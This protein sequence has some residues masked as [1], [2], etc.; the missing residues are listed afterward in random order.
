MS[1][2]KVSVTWKRN[3]P[4]FSYETYDRTHDWRFEGGTAVTATAAPEFKGNPDLVDPESAFVASLSSCHLLSFLAIAARKRFTVDSYADH[5]VGTLE[6]NAEGKL[7]MTRVVLRP[8]VT[9]GGE[10]APEQAEIRQLHE[11]AHAICFIAN[12]VRTEVVV[13]PVL[14]EG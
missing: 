6:K 3:T 7:A 5:A 9:F 10:N 14:D 12:S 2:H 1:E 4:D 13:D 11:R 8:R